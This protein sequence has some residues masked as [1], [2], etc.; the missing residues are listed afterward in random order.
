LT[1]KNEDLKNHLEAMETRVTEL[2]EH[3]RILVA[4]VSKLEAQ[5]SSERCMRLEIEEQALQ[6][7]RVNEEK[8]E[9]LHTFLSR[10]ESPQKGSPQSSESDDD[11]EL[12]IQLNAL[13][14]PTYIEHNS[15]E[16]CEP[17]SKKIKCSQ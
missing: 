11:R 14:S 9:L 17:P 15:A 16:I 5:L 1:K 8:R 3:E 10:M 4:Q 13:R 7:V 12:Y 6:L 2:V